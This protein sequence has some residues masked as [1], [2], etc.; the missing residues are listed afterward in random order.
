MSAIYPLPHSLSGSK[1]VPQPLPV[2]ATATA[3]ATASTISQNAWNP[4]P[5][6]A[7]RK[8]KRSEGDANTAFG[9]SVVVKSSA[10]GTAQLKTLS[11]SGKVYRPSQP[12]SDLTVRGVV[13]V[14]LPSHTPSLFPLPTQPKAATA[15]GSSDSAAAARGVNSNTA[16]RDRVKS[17]ME[18]VDRHLAR[19]E[20]Q[21][22]KDCLTEYKK[23]YSG[24][25]I[26]EKLTASWRSEWRYGDVLWAFEEALANFL[27][28][29]AGAKELIPSP[30]FFAA[31][32]ATQPQA[33]SSSGSGSG[34]SAILAK[35]KSAETLSARTVGPIAGSATTSKSP[36]AVQ[37]AVLTTFHKAVVYHP[38]QPPADLTARSV[39]QVNLPSHTPALSSLNPLASSETREDAMQGTDDDAKGA[40][41]ME[42]SRAVHLPAPQAS[43]ASASSAAPMSCVSTNALLELDLRVRIN[44]HLDC[45]E[46]QKARDC[47]TEYENL[48][49][50]E[51]SFERAE[52]WEIEGRLLLLQGRFNDAINA[53][54]QAHQIFPKIKNAHISLELAK[55]FL[56]G[57]PFPKH[58]HVQ[59]FLRTVLRWIAV[60]DHQNALIS[61]HQMIETF[62]AEN[63]LF[64]S[65]EGF[66]MGLIMAKIALIWLKLK[67]DPNTTWMMSKMAEDFFLQAL[68]NQIISNELKEDFLRSR[69][70]NYILMTQLAWALNKRSELETAINGLNKIEL[71]N[72]LTQGDLEA[73][74]DVEVRFSQVLREQSYA[75]AAAKAGEPQTVAVARIEE[76]RLECLLKWPCLIDAIKKMPL[77]PLDKVWADVFPVQ[78]FNS[79]LGQYRKLEK[80]WENLNSL[81]KVCG[82]YPNPL[83]QHMY[84][85]EMHQQALAL[86]RKNDFVSAFRC[87]RE[88]ENINKEFP[89]INQ[90]VLLEGFAFCYLQSCMVFIVDKKYD[91]AE[92]LIGKIGKVKT[93]QYFKKHLEK[94]VDLALEQEP[95]NH[96]FV[97]FLK[98]I[99]SPESQKSAASTSAHCPAGAVAATASATASASASSASAQGRNL[100]K[101]LKEKFEQH[102]DDKEF[103][104]ARECL[105]ECRRVDPTYLDP[106]YFTVC[107]AGCWDAEG[108]ELLLY[109]KY[110]QAVHAFEQALQIFPKTKNVQI[111]LDVA[112]RLAAAEGLPRHKRMRISLEA[113]QDWVAVGDFELARSYYCR[114]FKVLLAEKNS[115][116]KDY[117]LALI[118]TRCAEVELKLTLAPSVSLKLA[119]EA[120]TFFQNPSN[121]LIPGISKEEFLKNW[122][123]NHILN[124]RLNVASKKWGEALNS[125]NACR[126]IGA[127]TVEEQKDCDDVKAIISRE[128]GSV[129]NAIGALVIVGGKKRF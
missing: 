90:N 91:Q 103:Q 13:R 8:R 112:K 68:D 60:A 7:S 69:K 104:K 97:Q 40:Q 67:T 122:K 105:E 59:I 44:Q 36:V 29:S 65:N 50:V 77:Q 14:S 24:C 89:W 54:G 20:F 79:N 78:T 101:F 72:P 61:H 41:A 12:P 2:N 95:V 86:L 70:L 3:V 9:R 38:S 120:H 83:K 19:K 4:D 93:F 23:L 107:F 126:Q 32:L 76:Y 116:D 71:L 127:L 75:I 30:H 92:A 17:L 53:L 58:A 125:V 49:R 74:S 119:Q 110:A 45:M 55:L 108:V 57:L 47:L 35:Q 15:S 6:W 43:T 111:S 21:K 42:L 18:K 51:L 25:S 27:E 5:K 102:F 48:H 88:I 11:A 117:Y 63:F 46:F 10:D 22:A 113:P 115:S 109:Q 98:T 28:T 80:P 66:Y 62:R 121:A 96:A 56:T 16:D 33:A 82:F 52:C 123:R 114:M 64:D 26:S 129:T 94:L 39:T 1:A 37:S 128:Q 73:A 87:L 85:L 81:K 99:G 31:P 34:F 118:N 106:E 84:L 100:A 124:A